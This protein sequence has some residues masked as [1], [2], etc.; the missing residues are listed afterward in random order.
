MLEPVLRVHGSTE[1][2]WD[3]AHQWTLSLQRRGGAGIFQTWEWVRTWLEVFGSEGHPALLAVRDQH[4][5]ITG[6]APLLLEDRRYGP[7]RLKTLRLIGSGFGAEHLIVLGA[8]DPEVAA[9]WLGGE[10]AWDVLELGWMA[11][12]QAEQIK[13]EVARDRQRFRC[14]STAAASAPLLRLPRSWEAYQHSLSP[15]FRSGLT[16]SRRRLERD[17]GPLVIRQIRS[18]EE[19]EHAWDVLVRLHQVRWEARGRRGA[20]AHPGFGEFHRRFGRAALE[21][22]WLRFYVLESGAE[23][24]AALYCF[25]YGHS[26]S[27]F[28]GGFDPRWARYGPGRLLMAHAIR[29]AIEEGATEFDFLRGTERHKLHWK[30]V[31]RHD[32]HLVVYR[33]DPRVA[34]PVL[35]RQRFRAAREWVKRSA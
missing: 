21:R 31:L 2:L 4:G 33:K 25:Q 5:T 14:L 32:C 28:Q 18:E 22:S 6:L 19:F 16:R 8:M 9:R 7:F 20:F 26:V 34:M 24:L 13:R 1:S 11:E 3:L 29:A 30:P 23:V 27:Y 10:S 15:S 12:E 17:R 35:W